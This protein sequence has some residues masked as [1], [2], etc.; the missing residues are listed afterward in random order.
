M[1]AS[2]DPPANSSATT[3]KKK[4]NR[5]KKKKNANAQEDE[6]KRREEEAAAASKM[7]SHATLRNQLEQ[8]GFTFENID[9][10]M[11]EMWNLNLP[12]DEYD[13]VLKYL[14]TGGK[15]EEPAAEKSVSNDSN[16]T[17]ATECS[18][19]P[20]A[21]NTASS[22]SIKA[23][24]TLAARLDMVAGFDNMTDAIFALT[25]WVSKAAKPQEVSSGSDRR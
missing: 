16:A 14:K 21:P 4:R 13:A 23:P 3:N 6:Q 18:A 10:A 17:P 7:N 15:Q 20:E 8:E 22:S 11:E 25:E 1:T 24:A 19:E 5:K 9:R 2:D 12:Y